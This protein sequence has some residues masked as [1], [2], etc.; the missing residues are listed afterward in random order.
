[1]QVCVKQISEGQKS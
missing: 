1:M